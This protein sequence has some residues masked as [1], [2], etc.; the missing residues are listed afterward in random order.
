M[1]RPAVTAYWEG[2]H[3]GAYISLR[4]GSAGITAGQAARKMDIRASRLR[5]AMWGQIPVT[6]D[7]A[8][9]LQDCFGFSADFLIS[10]QRKFDARKAANRPVESETSAVP[11]LSLRLPFKQSV[12]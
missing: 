9:A 7:L 3:P 10:A 1:K 2:N 5:R 8:Q 4:F 12:P 11:S 6:P